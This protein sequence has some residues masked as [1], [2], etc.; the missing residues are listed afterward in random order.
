M[1]RRKPY[2]TYK[3]K[4]PDLLTVLV[5]ILFFIIYCIAGTM[6]YNTRQAE[7]VAQGVHTERNNID[8]F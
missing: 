4:Q 1:K 8:L 6:E 7:Q 3:D 2:R 5:V